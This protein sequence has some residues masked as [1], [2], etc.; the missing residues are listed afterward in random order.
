M[1]YG[2]GSYGGSGYTDPAVE[3]GGSE[4]TISTR[5]NGVPLK[6]RRGADRV[7]RIRPGMAEVERGRDSDWVSAKMVVDC[8]TVLCFHAKGVT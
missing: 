8:W 3:A 4:A 7:G 5:R 6:F 2:F 1:K